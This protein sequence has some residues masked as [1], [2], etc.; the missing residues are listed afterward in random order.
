[1]M[2][3]ALGR[4]ASGRNAKKKWPPRRTAENGAKAD[5]GEAPEAGTNNPYTRD[6]HHPVNA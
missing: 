3:G 2:A 6:R 5:K 1:M 4:T